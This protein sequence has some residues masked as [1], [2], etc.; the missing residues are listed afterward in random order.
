MT[1]LTAMLIQN[2]P[3]VYASAIG[4]VDNGEFGIYI[5]TL[6]ESP[7]GWKRPRMLLTSN[8]GYKTVEEALKAGR[9]MI[10]KVR[11]T[12]EPN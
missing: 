10:E 12:H 7:S 3:G 6:D 8:G 5:G 9:E 2:D 1:R 4:P 11:K